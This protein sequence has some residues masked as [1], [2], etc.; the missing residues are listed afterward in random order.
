MWL[1]LLNLKYYSTLTILFTSLSTIA[2]VYYDNSTCA[3]VVVLK[4]IGKLNYKITGL[5]RVKKRTINS[6]YARAIKRGFNLSL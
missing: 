5:T 4:A 3:A 2:I 6:I 1:V